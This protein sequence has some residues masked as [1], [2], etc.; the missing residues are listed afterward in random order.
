MLF[1]TDN[2]QTFTPGSYISVVYFSSYV[3]EK[4]NEPL[5]CSVFTFNY[6]KQSHKHKTSDDIFE[7]INP[8]LNIFKITIQ[9]LC[10][11]SYI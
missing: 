7:N 11:R 10:L 5:A 8:V 1:P 6:F 2:Y 4:K 9:F 3:S